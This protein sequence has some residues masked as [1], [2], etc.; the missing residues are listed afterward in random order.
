[1]LSHSLLGIF[2][3]CSRCLALF[4]NEQP[5]ASPSPLHH[6]VVGRIK[7]DNACKPLRTGPGTRNHSIK[8]S[9]HPPP[10]PR[11]MN[12]SLH[13]GINADICFI[14]LFKGLYGSQR[15]PQWVPAPSLAARAGL[16][17]ASVSAPSFTHTD[18]SEPSGSV[19]PPGLPCV[20]SH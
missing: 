14:L 6:G 3:S 7:L 1:M 10:P 5:D 12:I 9:F 19:S 17:S 15:S 11:F 18:L 13:I 4:Q 2:V 20:F 8:T 16:S